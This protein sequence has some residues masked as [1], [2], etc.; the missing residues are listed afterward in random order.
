M[1]ITLNT[2]Q[3]LKPLQWLLP[4]APRNGTLPVLSHI[5]FNFGDQTLSLTASNL[6]Q[7]ATIRLPVDTTE[8]GTFTLDAHKITSIVQS[9][10]ED[11]DIKFAVDEDKGTA[12]LRSDKSRFKLS[13][14]SAKLFPNF[15]I[16]IIEDRFDVPQSALR[17]LIT[18]TAFSM[19]K[20][21]A[22]YFLNGVLLEINSKKL[23]CVA[24]DG[25]RLAVMRSPV[26][27]TLDNQ[28]VIVPRKSV[29]LLK[30]L[31]AKDDTNISVGISKN[32]LQFKLPGMRLTC[33][34]IDGKF[35]DYQKVI[36][37][38]DSK[39]IDVTIP[40]GELVGMLNRVMVIGEKNLRVALKFEKSTLKFHTADADN[41]SL[42]DAIDIDN[43]QTMNT[44]FN[45]GYL[46][47]IVTNIDE[48][49][50]RFILFKEQDP[51]LI[52][53]ASNNQA[54]YLVMPMR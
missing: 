50:T 4:L 41:N 36:P 5:L 14:L 13:T 45:A 25:H 17:E 20:D 18:H 19:A 46:S 1:N 38:S 42:D 32:H 49:E 23:N 39:T 34:K 6:E 43:D 35:P 12:L 9:L 21:D 7:E 40:T 16:D 48:E 3:I 37:K 31:L 51:V 29:E 11:S 28:Q 22:R 10:P 24:T 27:V 26:P 44:C 52:S 54:Q 2:S 53:P 8:E 47:D 30:K 33:K 15:D